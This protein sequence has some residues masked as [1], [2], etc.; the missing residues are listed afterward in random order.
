M[1]TMVR[2]PKTE[3]RQL[4]HVAKQYDL[5]RRVFTLNFFERPSTRSRKQIMKGLK[6]TGT[7]NT[8]FLKSLEK[9]LKESSYFT[10]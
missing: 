3:Y 7:Y 10:S 6:S 5:L 8:A 2:I 1:E 9:G 4:T